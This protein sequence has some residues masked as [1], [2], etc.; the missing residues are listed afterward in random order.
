MTQPNRKPWITGQ[1][2]V[3]SKLTQQDVYAIRSKRE[4]GAKFRELADQ[5]GVGYYTI[6]DVIQGVSWGHLH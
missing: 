1:H 4:D 5:F 6:R 3:R 2:K